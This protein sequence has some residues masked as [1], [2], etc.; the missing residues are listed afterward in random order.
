MS[1]ESSN[2]ELYRSQ[3]M[4][5]VGELASGVAHDFNNLLMA[6]Q[7]NAE[8]L[9]LKYPNPEAE[10]LVNNILRACQSGSFLAKSLLGYAKKQALL[11]TV[12][13]VNRL[14]EEVVNLCRVSHGPAYV[15]TMEIQPGMGVNAC[16]HSLCHCLLN[17]INNAAEAMPAGGPIGIRCYPEEEF[18]RIDVTDR[19]CGIEPSQLEKI[20]DPY[21]T[22]K[23]DG[24]GLGLSMVKSI[25]EEH[26]GK[27][28]IFSQPGQGTTVSLLLPLSSGPMKPLDQKTGPLKALA[29][30][31]K[32]KTA[33]ILDDEVQIVNTMKAFLES[34]GYQ[35]KG[36]HDPEG[37]IRLINEEGAPHVLIS[38]YS[39]PKMSGLDTL[40]A[41]VSR[42]PEALQKTHVVLISGFPPAEFAEET[43][44]LPFTVHLLQK[45]FSFQT[46]RNFLGQAR[47][48]AGPFERGL[49]MR[50]PIPK[51]TDRLAGS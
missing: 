38:D 30:E 43:Q 37:L 41:I 40:R 13:P 6:I 46:F 35:V 16:Y 17:I 45:P 20:F 3:T 39:L 2:S 26:S 21:F 33:Y 47:D 18:A 42:N 19:G 31:E 14:I 50:I 11:R 8:L 1:N 7:G 44:K 9:K 28:G 51:K 10:F 4:Q 5:Q 15:I 48:H 32:G 22:T 25:V 27:V 36:V 49:S 34:L 24:S 23:H 12:F 29:P